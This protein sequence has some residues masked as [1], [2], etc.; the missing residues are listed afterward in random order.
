MWRLPISPVH[1]GCLPGSGMTELTTPP[2]SA[3]VTLRSVGTGGGSATLSAH[4]DAG[5]HS[6]VRLELPCRIL[7]GGWTSNPRTWMPRREQ[8]DHLIRVLTGGRGRNR[9]PER[10]APRFPS[11]MG[12]S[13]SALGKWQPKKGQR[14]RA[15]GNADDVAAPHCREVVN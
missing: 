7:A 6:A 8:A 4:T 13:R 10:D 12:L 1:G 11:T 9:G 14:R 3:P 5:C 15:A 2:R